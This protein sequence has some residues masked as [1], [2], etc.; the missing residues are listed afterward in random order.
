MAIRFLSFVAILV[1]F[2]GCQST[3]PHPHLQPA[4]P[5][6]VR[7]SIE[8]LASDALQG[9]GVG[10]AGLEEAGDYIAGYFHMLGLRPAASADSYYQNFEFQI[11]TGPSKTS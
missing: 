1:F 4:S 3:P 6:A 11:L 2:T 9:R 5:Q 10:S 7:N 8:Y